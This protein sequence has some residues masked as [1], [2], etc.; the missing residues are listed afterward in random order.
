MDNSDQVGTVFDAGGAAGHE[1]TAS[2]GSTHQVP[3]HTLNEREALNEGPPRPDL[4][5]WLAL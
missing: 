2:R 4:A 3:E 5:G 1:G